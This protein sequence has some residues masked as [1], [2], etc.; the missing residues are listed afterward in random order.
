MGRN[1]TVVV[2]LALSWSGLWAAGVSDDGGITEVRE[3]IFGSD[4][5]RM[6][7]FIQG[8]NSSSCKNGDRPAAD[9]VEHVE[10]LR[11]SLKR[12]VEGVD[13][14]SF[15]YYA[16]TSREKSAA[17][18]V[19]SGEPCCPKYDKRDACWS[20]DD[21]Y[22]LRG[23]G[24][25]NVIGQAQRLA[26]YIDKHVKH[27]AK[28]TIVAHSQG[29]VLA[30]YTAQMLDRQKWREIIPGPVRAIVTL[31]SPLR[32]ISTVAAH[33]LRVR[34]ACGSDRREDSH[35]DMEAGTQVIQ[36][37]GYGKMPATTKL[38][39]IDAHPGCIAIPLPPCPSIAEKKTESSWQLAHLR[40]EAKT[41]SD[42]WQG[43]FKGS[44]ERK[45][46]ESFIACA[47]GQFSDNCE[48]Y[49]DDSGG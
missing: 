20:L 27:D 10:W 30:A 12:D 24:R 43:V 26:T 48:E 4:S 6:V 7:L 2:V 22:S 9:F 35:R 23:A 14:D 36:E 39:T 17:R 38:Y 49:A 21:E 29:G 31:D 8:I 1:I 40:A 32:G 19:C 42:I 25:G 13:D 5:D 11:E 47:V 3:W 41:H 37:A 15:L 34:G 44:A 46:V 16:Y 18:P 28:L 33:G 45:R